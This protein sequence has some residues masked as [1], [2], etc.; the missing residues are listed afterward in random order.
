VPAPDQVRG[1][2]SPENAL[3]SIEAMTVPTRSLRITDSR[4]RRLARCLAR[5]AALLVAVATPGAIGSGLCAD[6]STGTPPAHTAF[7][8]TEIADGFFKIVFGAEF[9]TGARTDRIRKYEGAI[10]IFIADSGQA[11]RRRQIE[12]IIA[13]IKDRV[14]GLD[15]GVTQDRANANML[16]SL[17]R[18]RDLAGTITKVYGRDRA[19]S[20]Q[21]SLEP[22]CLSGFRKDD[23]YRI[24][25]S[26]VILVVDAGEFVFIDCAYEEM[27]QALGP[28]NDDASVPWSMFNDNVQLGFFGLYDQYLLNIL[29]HPRMR[30]GMTREE[31]AAMLPGILP[32]VRAFVAKKNGLE[33]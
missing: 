27:L 10:R 4:P 30:P 11:E 29:Y 5:A 2:S 25:H 1:G 6:N 28:I 23:S 31:A 3:P 22:Q 19:R 24:V 18:D 16:V 33:H 7:T 14:A 17:V 8:D 21:S 26:D 9:H 32:E 12:T 15:I 13:D 20:I